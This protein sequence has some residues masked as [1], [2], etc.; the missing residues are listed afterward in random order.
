MIKEYKNISKT[1]K[2]ILNV[3][4]ENCRQ[5][6]SQIAKKV[7]LSKE[8]VRYRIKNMERKRIIKIIKH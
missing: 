8:L 1:D 2:N 5:N 6:Y 3:L 7:R 4:I